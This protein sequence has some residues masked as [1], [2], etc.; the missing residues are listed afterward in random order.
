ML[1][2]QYTEG[3]FLDYR[4][5]DAQNITPRYAFGFGLSYTTFSY[6][7]LSIITA[8]SPSAYKVTFTVA[9]SG[10]VKGTEIPQLYLAFPAGNGEP[11]VILRGFDEV[12][13]LA[14]G[15]SKTVTLTLSEREVRYVAL[16][17]SYFV[18]VCSSFSSIFYSIWNVV[19]QK[20]TRPSG[21]YTVYIGAS[22]KDI[23]LTGTFTL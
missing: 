17:R 18:V 19:Q 21:T 14:S 10:P 22:I 8:S 11:K 13:D 1:Q 16:L 12:R 7:S 23:R 3:L 5:M 2:I 9:N 4:Y 20:W 15:Q 6:S